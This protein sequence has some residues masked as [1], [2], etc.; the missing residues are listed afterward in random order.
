MVEGGSTI[1]QQ[2][3][4]MAFLTPERSFV[5]KVKEALYTLWIEARFD[6]A[7]ILELYLN[8]SISAAGRTGSMPRRGAISPGRRAI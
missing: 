2:L 4:K 8:R 5:R 7:K 3:A 6:K 1:S